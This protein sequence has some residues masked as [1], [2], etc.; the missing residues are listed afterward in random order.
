M[1]GFFISFLLLAT[2][3]PTLF[4]L[5]AAKETDPAAISLEMKRWWHHFFFFQRKL[6][7]RF[8]FHNF[9]THQSTGYNPF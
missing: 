7:G 6:P 4:H 5:F 9:K 2:A 3:S 8:C 1:V